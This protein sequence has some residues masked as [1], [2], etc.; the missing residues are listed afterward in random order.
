L[1]PLRPSYA[2]DNKEKINVAQPTMRGKAE[3][4]RRLNINGVAA[5]HNINAI[6]KSVG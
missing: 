2:S 3:E 1:R 5:K 6:P 4:P